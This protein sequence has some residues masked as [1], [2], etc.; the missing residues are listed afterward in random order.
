VNPTPCE[1]RRAIWLASISF[2]AA[3][4]HRVEPVAIIHHLLGTAEQRRIQQLRQHPELKM[5]TL[6][7]R[8]G[9][10]ERSRE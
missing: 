7:R 2:G 10:E 4:H 1:Q 9:E 8:G 5:V 3:E 6:V